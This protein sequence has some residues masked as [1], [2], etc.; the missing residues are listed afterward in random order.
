VGD[1]IEMG[2]SIYE[3]RSDPVRDADRLI[4]TAEAREL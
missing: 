3:V 4:W 1:T 2:A